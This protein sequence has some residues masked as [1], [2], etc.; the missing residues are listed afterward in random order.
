MTMKPCT[1]CL[2]A[3]LTIVLLSGCA[4]RQNP[5]RGNVISFLSQTPVRGIAE[6][7]AVV[8]DTAIIADRGFGFSMYDLS[9][10]AHPRLV[11]SLL[12]LNSSNLTYV[13]VDSSGRIACTQG[14]SS[15]EFYDLQNR[16][17]LFV[18]GSSQHF[19][20]QFMYDGQDLRLYDG[21]QSVVDG[22]FAEYYHNS[23]TPENPVFTTPYFFSQY[24]YH[25]SGIIGASGFA[26]TSDN[27]A[28]VCFNQYGI[29]LVEYTAT[30]TLVTEFNTPGLTMD[31]ALAGNLLCLASGFEGLVI[32]DVS[33]DTLPRVLSSLRFNNSPNIERVIVSGS[34]AYLM[35][36]YDGV[37]AVDISDP[38]A[39][40]MIGF[41]TASTPIDFAVYGNLLV[42]A[43]I[44]AGLIIGQIM[45]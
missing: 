31:A 22:F 3:V 12:T 32:V 16:S 11:D 35:D 10:P 40:Q 34:R 45:Y 1:I 6:G 2:L 4:E 38:S 36:K 14:P 24:N 42:I 20:M 27:R 43:D 30:P 39:P 5:T 19:K 23:G 28:W 37:Y 25:S 33:N 18:A 29:G 7:V 17:Y 44:D 41:L 26:L 13:A 9:D 21:D 8:N 15:L